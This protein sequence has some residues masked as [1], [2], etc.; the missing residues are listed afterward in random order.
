[1]WAAPALRLRRRSK[2]GGERGASRG[3]G[4]GDGDG[5]AGW[6][7][8]ASATPSATTVAPVVVTSPPALVPTVARAAAVGS[9]ASGS[10]STSA[11]TSTSREHD[12]ALQEQVGAIDRA[13]AALERGDAGECLA[14]LARYDQTFPG[15]DALAGGDAASRAGPA[16]ARRFARARRSLPIGSSRATPRART[17]RRCGGCSSRIRDQPPLSPY[18]PRCGGHHA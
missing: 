3:G 1:M 6:W 7:R 5:P 18:I 13:R 11:S 10:T 8:R 4:G 9:V 15:G 14:L 16:P 17:S 12:V 2:R